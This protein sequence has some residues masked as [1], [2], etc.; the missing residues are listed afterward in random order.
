MSRDFGIFMPKHL[1][2]QW[3]LNSYKTADNRKNSYLQ[4]KD[5]V[6]REESREVFGIHAQMWCDIFH[7]TVS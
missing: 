4:K 3:L 2:V 1:A 6:I 7:Q 5:I